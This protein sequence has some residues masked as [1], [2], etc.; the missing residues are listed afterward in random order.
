VKTDNGSYFDY[1]G[2]VLK[3][4]CYPAGALI[5]V[6]AFELGDPT[7]SILEIWGAEYQESNA[8]LVHADHRSLLKQIAAREKC[9]V[10]FVGLITD[11]GKVPSAVRICCVFTT[12]RGMQ[13]RSSNDNSLRPSL[14]QKRNL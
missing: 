1:V 10:S 11:D 13:T 14:C 8:L 3:E 6:S 9:P 7:L 12:L 2:N 5:N 4:I